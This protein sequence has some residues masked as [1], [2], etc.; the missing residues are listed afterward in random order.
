MVRG[1][2]GL[3]S[4]EPFIAPFTLTLALCE[5]SRPSVD[6]AEIYHIWSAAVQKKADAMHRSRA[7]LWCRRSNDGSDEDA[8]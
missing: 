1:Y 6:K 3:P 8:L 2:R 7:S 5:R 4:H